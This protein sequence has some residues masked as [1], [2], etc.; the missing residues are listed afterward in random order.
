MQ[1]T[2]H[3]IANF[4]GLHFNTVQKWKKTR[5]IIYKALL[6]YYMKSGVTNYGN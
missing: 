6:D 1:P 4:Y 3:N 5:P 2:V